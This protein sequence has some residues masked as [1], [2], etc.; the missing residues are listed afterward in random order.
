MPVNSIYRDILEAVKTKIT[1]LGLAGINAANVRVRKLDRMRGLGAPFV[2][3]SPVSDSRQSATNRSDAV[4]YGVAIVV[5]DTS[6][7]DLEANLDTLLGHRDKIAKAFRPVVGQ[8]ILPGAASV[9][10]SVFE[11]GFVVSPVAF[12]G[13]YD[14]Q[15]FTI[16]FFTREVRV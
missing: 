13:Q 10:D 3:V 15:A 12:D 6:N 1:A 16:R 4:G 8:S 14:V 7:Q 5:G 11:S 9:Y 2:V